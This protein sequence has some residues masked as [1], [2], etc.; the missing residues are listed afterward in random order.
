MS[1]IRIIA[2]TLLAGALA[3]VSVSQISPDVAKKSRDIQAKMRQ[4]EVVNQLIPLVM[5][6]DQVNK[7][8]V[9]I[10]KCRKREFELE[11]KEAAQLRSVEKKLNEAL[12]KG[13]LEGVVPPNE[14]IGELNT[15][16]RAF[17]I[18]RGTVS[19][20]NTEAMLAVMKSTLNAGQLKAAEKSVNPKESNPSAEPEK[21]TQDERLRY[22]I[23]TVM[24]DWACYDVLV[25]LAAKPA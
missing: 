10:E 22:F 13:I 2:T 15:M 4:L 1:W 3:A 7:V 21:M 11:A 24:L 20:E 5:T 23:R 17:L 9:V 16:Y 19:E 25:R 18:G 8:L 6:K 14:L 12:D